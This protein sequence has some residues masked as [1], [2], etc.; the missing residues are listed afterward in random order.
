MAETLK[1]DL[2]SQLVKK[3]RKKAMETY[4]YRKGSMKKAMEDLLR[5]YTREG[6]PDWGKMIGV[7]DHLKNDSVEL[8]HMLWKKIK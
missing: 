5:Q 8:Q 3:F 6:K 2:D 4:G 1:V 7:L